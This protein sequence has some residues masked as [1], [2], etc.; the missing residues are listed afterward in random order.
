MSHRV[1]KARLIFASWA[2]WLGASATSLPWAHAQE[3]VRAYYPGISGSQ[4]PLFVASDLGLFKKHGL[5][6]DVVFISGAAGTAAQL[7][8]EVQFG[9]GQSF[10]TITGALAG[11]DTV[12]AATYLNKLLFSFVTTP[13]IARP[14]D[15]I[16]KKIGVQSIGS[17]NSLTVSMALREWGIDE[18]KVFVLRA[19]EIGPRL[20][21]LL[22]GNLDATIVT[23]AEVRRA[24][25]AG[26][27]ILG[28]LRS[29]RGSF[30]LASV[31]VRKSYLQT[32]RNAAKKFL[33][34]FSEGIHLFQTD[35]EQGLKSITKWMKI[36]ERDTLEDI[37]Q[38]FAPMMSL[39]PKTDLGGVQSILDF[40]AKSRPEA[41]KA[42]PQDVVDEGIL[43]ELEREGFFKA[44]L[45]E[46]KK[47]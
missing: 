40:L 32:K 30:P 11:A 1:M 36:R 33:M 15:L 29:L 37:Y 42:G 14:S 27:R 23:T 13:E 19:G 22:A 8:G 7:A 6:V 26:L 43:I 16:G 35:K 12:I 41:K 25:A 45:K 18:S 46:V 21:A 34:A 20:Q 31:T 28:D 3:R 5:D 24:R 17:L 38:A 10:T 9:I 2:L 47:P 39:P 4:V 44:L